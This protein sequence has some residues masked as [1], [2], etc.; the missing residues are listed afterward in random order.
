MENSPKSVK[1]YSITLFLLSFVLLFFMGR[2]G[3]KL[4]WIEIAAFGFLVWIAEFFGIDLPKVGAISVS[5]AVIFAAILLFDPL[6]VILISLFAAIV[7][8]DIKNKTSP[9]RWILNAS[10][11]I[12]DAGL[13]A[14][15]YKFA[16]GVS[17]ITKSGLGSS[18]FPAILIPLFLS[19][20]VYLI[21]NSAL[22]SIAIG[23]YLNTSP[24][25]AWLA[26]AKRAIPGYLILAPLGLVIAQL[27]V[28][29]GISAIALVVVPLLIARE[30]FKAYMK[31]RSAYGDTVRALI[32]SI[33]A[34]NS[35]TKGHSERV[36]DYVEL[37]A[38]KMKFPENEMDLIKY[39][40]LLH[41][42]GK[43]GIPRSILCKPSQLTADEYEEIKKHSDIGAIL[44]KDIELLKNVLPVVESH[45][46]YYNGMGYGGGIRGESIPLLARVVSVA[47]AFDAMT[48]MRAYRDAMTSA[49]AAAELLSCAGSRFDREVV[50]KFV[51]MLE[52]E[53]KLEP[54][55]VGKRMEII[56]VEEKEENQ[57]FEPSGKEDPWE[58]EFKKNKSKPKNGLG[59][60]AGFEVKDDLLIIDDWD[61]E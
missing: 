7:R 19:A 40:A 55:S 50:K 43:I 44:L 53:G 57:K 39:G 52:E 11:A 54:D 28:T 32:A 30:S 24:F 13:A 3:L 36:A 46:E 35:Y 47:D 21:I 60:E 41:D 38:R 59:I 8:L 2:A 9:F 23:L 6:A 61:L 33:E 1:I 42:L 37:A 56:C 12:F 34:K 20:A 14:L 49:E 45:H 26:N 5:F 4:P 17:L 29:N 25:R 15:F 22:V 27:Y 31:L 18:D 58:K 10:I 16:G 48:S 51:E